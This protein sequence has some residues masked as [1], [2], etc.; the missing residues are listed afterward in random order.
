MQNFKQTHLRENLKNEV[1]RKFGKTLK[2]SKDCKLLSGQIFGV[3]GRQLSVSTIKRFFEIIPSPFNPSKYTLDTFSIFLGFVNWDSYVDAK[4]SN[5]CEPEVK[6]CWDVLRENVRT[7]T[8][9]SIHSLA[10]KTTYNSRK[11]IQRD[12]AEDYF[13]GFFLSNKTAA[14]LVAPKGYGKSSV[15][16]Q[17]HYAHFTGSDIRFRKDVVCLIDGGI[18]FAFLISHKIIKF[19]TN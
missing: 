16:M 3:T 13:E 14:I 11:F 7:I 19:L 18:L 17:W 2:Y 15:L 12:F 8:D 10:Q 9:T 5:E 1:E 4:K 6:N